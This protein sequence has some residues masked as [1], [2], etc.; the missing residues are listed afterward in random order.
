VSV[1]A[2]SVDLGDDRLALRPAQR[3]AYADLGVGETRMGAG[4]F[5]EMF[6]EAVHV[7][8]TRKESAVCRSRLSRFSMALRR[9]WRLPTKTASFLARVSPV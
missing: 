9:A 1:L 6:K 7:E 3:P 2:E 5:D 8:L 4:D